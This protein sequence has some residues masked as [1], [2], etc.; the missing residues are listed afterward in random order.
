MTEPVHVDEA[1]MAEIH[2]AFNARDVARICALFTEDGVF[3][4]ARGPHPY[5]ERYVGREAIGK[6]LAERFANIPDMSWHH[7][8]RWF[9]GNRAVSYWRVTG[10]DARRATRIR[11]LRPLRVRESQDQVQGHALEA[12]GLT[13]PAAPGQAD[14]SGQSTGP[15]R[16][17]STC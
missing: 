12:A 15:V 7:H 9:H 3:A 17:R 8:Y 6:F 14:G 16:A 13:L 10:K 5:G 1:L 2:D 11:R 4:T